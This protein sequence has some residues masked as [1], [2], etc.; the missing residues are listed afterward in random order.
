[1]QGQ[2]KTSFER[3]H[4]QNQYQTA[5]S[6]EYDQGVKQRS[7]KLCRKHETEKVEYENEEFS[8][9]KGFRPPTWPL[10]TKNFGKRACFFKKLA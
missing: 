7:Q 2:W 4:A 5:I 1:M 8:I 9:E 10:K 6:Q 3:H